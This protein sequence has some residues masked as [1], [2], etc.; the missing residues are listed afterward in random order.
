MIMLALAI[1]IVFRHYQHELFQKSHYFMAIAILYT[2]WRHLDDAPRSRRLFVYLAAGVFVILVLLRISRLLLRNV[3]RSK[4]GGSTVVTQIQDTVRVQIKV[5]RPWKIR[6]GQYVYI[7]M[8]GV[9]FWSTFQSHPFVI[10][11]WDDVQGKGVNI[12]LL[13][14]PRSGFTGKLLRHTGSRALSCWIDGP[15][16]LWLNAADYGSVLMFATGIGIAA[17]VPYVKEILQMRRESKARTQ[18]ISL[19]WQLNDDSE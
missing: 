12:Y 15:Y 1:L 9:S 4:A 2:A 11:W 8:S 5:P 10:S 13:I 6:A 14:S 19:I 17:Q 16:G 18:N 3:T 7:W